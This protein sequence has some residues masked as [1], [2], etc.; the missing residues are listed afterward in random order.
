MHLP[1]FIFSKRFLF[2]LSFLLCILFFS[3]FIQFRETKTHADAD[4]SA[5]N[6]LVLDKNA[7]FSASN[8]HFSSTSNPPNKKIILDWTGFFGEPLRKEY[9][10]SVCLSMNC[11]ITNDRRFL[12]QSS[13]LIFHI[14]DLKWNDLPDYRHPDQFYALLSHESPANTGHLNL[15]LAPRGFF[16]LTLTYRILNPLALSIPM[17]EL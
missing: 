16:N 5:E 8:P 15:K 7:L 14:A 10:M 12:R 9:Q 1:H 4:F 2:F 17:F 6:T 13:V 11:D 3:Y